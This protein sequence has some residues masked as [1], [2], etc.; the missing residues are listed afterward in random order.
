MAHFDVDQYCLI[1]TDASDIVVAAVFSQ[2]G[3]DG[4]YHPVVYF[5]KLMA[6]AKINYPIYNKEMLA[7]VRAF[8]H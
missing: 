8:K 4:E 2:L 3:L 5:S 7:I 1:E 6:L